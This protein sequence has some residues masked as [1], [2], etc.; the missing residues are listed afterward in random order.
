VHG[1]PRRHGGRL[2]G[3]NQPVES[4][5]RMDGRRSA[6]VHPPMTCFADLL[7]EIESDPDDITRLRLIHALR[8]V[9]GGE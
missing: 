9:L 8:E 4:I 5:G 3:L 7:A 2:R 1:R 6:P